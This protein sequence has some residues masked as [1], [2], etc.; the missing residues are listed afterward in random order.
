M[1]GADLDR[2]LRLAVNGLK[3]HAISLR[4]L[5]ERG[6]LVGICR[7][8][9]VEAEANGPEADRRVLGDAEGAAEI[10]IPLG[11]DR[12]V[13]HGDVEGGGDR[14]QGDASA[15]HQGFQQHVAG[16]GGDA[17]APGG[18]MKASLHQG[19]A[20]R[21]LAG[22]AFVSKLA[23]GLESDDRRL[24]GVAVALLQGRLQGSEIVGT[25]A[26]LVR[27]ER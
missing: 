20:G 18:G 1:S 6:Q 25:H 19:P 24:G 15:G 17:I 12:A 22:E 16:A 13:L 8:F 11:A 9:E 27:L 14:L 7:S 23:L 3:Y 4:K 10:Q 26:V 5:D 2:E 21:H